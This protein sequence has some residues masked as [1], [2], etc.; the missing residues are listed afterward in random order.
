MKILM[1]SHYTLPH[2]GGIEIIIEKLSSSLAAQGHEIRVVASKYGMIAPEKIRNREIISINAFDP[3]RNAG[4]HY[5]IFSPAIIPNIYRAVHWADIIHAQGML[6]QNSLL[7]L[8]LAKLMNKPAL[9]TEHAGFVQYR[10][11]FFNSIQRIAVDTLGKASLSLSKSVI[12]PDTIVREILVNDLHISDEKIV[13]I[14][15]GVDTEV[16]HPISAREKRKLRRELHWNNRPKVLFIGNFVPRKRIP[17]L[18]EAI[19]DKFD[20]VLCGEGERPISLPERVYVYPAMGHEKI[21]KLYQAADIFVIPSSVETFSI[22]AYEAMACGLPVVMTEDLAHLTV[23]KSKLAKITSPNSAA[24][25]E[26][27]H[28]LINDP[29]EI[30]RIGIASSDWVKKNFSW[31]NS[32]MQHVHLYEKVF[33]SHSL[34]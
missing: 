28:T 12:V 1:T 15:L 30:E 13:Q 18:L 19:S 3:L 32:V 14:S 33:A 10:Y 7:A 5:P 17:L 21:V 24:L 16:F 11:P 9:L 29:G 4:V 2:Q 26:Q 20:I 22:V 6:Y 31:I 23:A 8:W 34:L 25:Q 27:I